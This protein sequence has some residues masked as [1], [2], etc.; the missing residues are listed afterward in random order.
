M[1]LP[2]I[3]IKEKFISQEIAEKEQLAVETLES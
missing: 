2:S 1:K 3:L